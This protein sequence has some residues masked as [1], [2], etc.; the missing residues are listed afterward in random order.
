MRFVR[1]LSLIAVLL[2]SLM[3]G[4]AT[5]A[6]DTSAATL[7]HGYFS[8]TL[9][10]NKLETADFADG[11]AVAAGLCGTI[12]YAYPPAGLA[13]FARAGEII[14][15]ANRAENRNMCLKMKY[16][17]GGAYWFDIYSG[18]YCR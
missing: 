18:K 11:E 6:P 5:T 8:S 17:H 12:T 10:F 7:T 1:R 2:G 13:C 4:A 16:A 3:V 14:Y 15:Q 9:Y